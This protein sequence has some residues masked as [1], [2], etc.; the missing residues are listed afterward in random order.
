[1]KE[2]YSY[3]NKRVFVLYNPK[4]LLNRYFLSN[5]KYIKIIIRKEIFFGIPK[6][7]FKILFKREEILTIYKKL[8][9]QFSLKQKLINLYSILLLSRGICKYKN[10]ILIIGDYQNSLNM[11][12]L[13]LTYFDENIEFWI[14]NQGSGSMEKKLNYRYPKTV[15]KVFFPYA[16][17]SLY[18]E[19]LLSKASS[20]KRDIVFLNIDTTL[21]INLSNKLNKL[22]I[23]HGYDK[24]YK[25]YP[26]YF[27]FIIKEIFLI[28]FLNELNNF[29]KVDFFL[30]PRL[31]YLLIF[32]F[33]NLNNNICYKIFDQKI[34]H[35]YKYIISYSPT[36]NSSIDN[37]IKKSQ[38]YIY[39]FGFN[40][41]KKNIQKNI[42]E[43]LR[44]SLIKS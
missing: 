23:F 31:K 32:Q 1:M 39:Q 15:R 43:L 7:I 11:S 42:N 30:H 27:I 2:F 19:N 13:Q 33:L 34:A 5:E 18:E 6:F 38:K 41:N 20:K 22:A 4:K 9:E 3:E 21:K 10:S 35:K 14:I 36:I 24:K 8:P 40:F 26:I 44:N 37:T 17:E 12:V 25:L 29:D 16:K 28:N